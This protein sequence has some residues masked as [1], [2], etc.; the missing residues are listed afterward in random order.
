M[1]TLSFTL[2]IL[3]V[4][5]IAAVIVLVWGTVK[6]LKQGKQID[7][8][9]KWFQSSIDNVWRSKEEDRRVNYDREERFTRELDKRFENFERMIHDEV[10][11]INLKIE[12]VHRRIDEAYRQIYQTIDDQNLQSKSYTDSRIDKLIDTY[13]EM[14]GISSKKQVIKG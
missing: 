8:N 14:K 2:G 5:I 13:F 12:D 6:V 9:N 3:S 10:K 11:E 4:I 1:E 7:E